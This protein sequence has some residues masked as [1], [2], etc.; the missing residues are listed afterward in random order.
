MIVSKNLLSLTMCSVRAK[1]SSNKTSTWG[2]CSVAVSNNRTKIDK[3][4]VGKKFLHLQ[5]YR[6]SLD[7]SMKISNFSKIVHN[8]FN[9]TL[10]SHSTPKR[11]PVWAM[12]SKSYDWDVR[13]IGK[14]CPKTAISRLCSIFSKLS[15]WLERN[16]LQSFYTILESYM[17]NGIKIVWLRSEKLSPK[18]TK[19]ILV[20]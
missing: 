13:N 9:E 12:A 1:V 14:I 3:I 11:A 20:F 17:C 7:L 2:K 5:L 16:F 18:I 8:D 19:V 4:G 15:I 6:F 10:H